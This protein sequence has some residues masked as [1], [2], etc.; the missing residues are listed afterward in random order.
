MW[1]GVVVEGV[2]EEEVRVGFE[3]DGGLVEVPGGVMLELMLY[4]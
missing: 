4:V 3:E 1:V 2:D